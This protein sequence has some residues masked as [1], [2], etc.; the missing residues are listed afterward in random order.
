MPIIFPAAQARCGPHLDHEVRAGHHQWVV[1]AAALG[2]SVQR[3]PQHLP[4]I[5]AAVGHAAER[6]R[7]QD[8]L[9]MGEALNQDSSQ[10]VRPPT[11]M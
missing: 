1:R 7:P 3:Q 10:P 4:R 2:R 5:D 6:D 8:A 11:S 9:Q